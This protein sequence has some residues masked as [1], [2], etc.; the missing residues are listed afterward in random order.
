MEPIDVFSSTTMTGFLG[1]VAGIGAVCAYGYTQRGPL[2]RHALRLLGGDAVEGR[3]HIMG[4]D[5]DGREG[6]RDKGAGSVRK[7]RRRR[8]GKGTGMC[9]HD[10]EGG[11]DGGHVQGHGKADEKE[12]TTTVL[13]GDF[14]STV[15]TAGPYVGP[16]T[17]SASPITAAGTEVMA[18]NSGKTKKRKKKNLNQGRVRER[19][20]DN[21]AENKEAE[22]DE[23]REASSGAGKEA[24]IVGGRTAAAY[25][26]CSGDD[27][28]DAS[29]SFSPP[30]LGST[31]GFSSRS[32]AGKG[33]LRGSTTRPH[34]TSSQPQIQ[35]RP[36]LS[37]DTDSSWTHVDPIWRPPASDSP[38]AERA[39]NT[40]DIRGE[41][42][43]LP[44]RTLAEK[45]VPKPSKTGVDDMLQK[46]DFPTLARV[47]RVQPRADET[48]VAGFSWDD[49]GDVLEDSLLVHDAD[50]ED[51]GE[52]G[53]V[54]SRSRTR[55]Q[56]QTTTATPSTSHDAATADTMTKKQR[57]NARKR[58]LAKAAK[59]EAEA[60]RLQGLAKHKH[61]LERLRIIE[62][63]QQGGGKRPS[64]GMQASVDDRGKLVWE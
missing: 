5:G 8:R 3:T 32:V 61:E 16:R 19:D 41:R 48:P 38:V 14:D 59:A 46:P 9:G 30:V 52:W 44:Q 28:T 40:T 43:D 20:N 29:V 51:E 17:T 26:V 23:E 64:G 6:D 1:V 57:Q 34:V 54:R 13:P 12:S 39:D 42:E 35:V 18:G 21:D 33:H 4:G 53:I 45:L 7:V 49:Y 60:A 63:S 2:T 55:P 58:E 62:Q 10:G 47:M 15:T 50:Q 27:S 24:G 36:S 31:L 25:L 22:E 37:F 11:G 56:Q